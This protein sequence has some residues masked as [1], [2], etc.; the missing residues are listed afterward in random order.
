LPITALRLHIPH[1]ADIEVAQALR[2]YAQQGELDA[3]EAMQALRR[4]SR[5]GFCSATR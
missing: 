5:A 2:R 4:S 3:A 1:L